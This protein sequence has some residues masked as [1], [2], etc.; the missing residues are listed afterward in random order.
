MGQ[1][2]EKEENITEAQGGQMT[3]HSGEGASG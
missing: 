3:L 2:K 1:G